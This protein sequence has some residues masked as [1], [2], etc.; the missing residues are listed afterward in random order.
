[1]K[2]AIISDIHGNL[3]AFQTVL[4][5]LEDWKPDHVLVA[6]DVVNRGPRSVP[7]LEIVQE[8]VETADWRLVRGNHEDYILQHTKPDVPRTGPVGEYLRS[9]YWTYQ[10]LNGQVPYL[11]SMPFQQQLTGPDGSVVRAVHASMLANNIGIYKSTTDEELQEMVIP[12]PAILAVGHTHQPLIRR[13][14]DTLIINAGSVGT[15]F[16]G[17]R[18]ASYARLEWNDEKGWQTQIVRLEFDYETAEKDYYRT[19]YLEE[20]GPLALLMLVE[21]RN[22]HGYLNRWHE[23]YIDDIMSGEISMADSVTAYMASAGL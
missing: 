22:A 14:N 10:Q 17:D 16:D 12:A 9:S 5:D 2:I 21:F 7:C 18:R 4:Q 1:M 15:P 3:P 11:K 19:N 23:M 13:I 8:K 20:A 6:G